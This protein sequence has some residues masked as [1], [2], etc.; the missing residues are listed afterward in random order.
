[1]PNDAPEQ[2]A[3][4]AQGAIPV[5]IAIIMDGNGRWA[6][7][8]GHNRVVGHYEG[9]ESV[10]DITEACAQLGVGYLTLYTFSTENW[11]RP[12]TEVDALM[13]LLIHSIQRERDT[14]MRN[15]IRL[16]VLGDLA[17]L[18]AACQ[19]A[20]L[21]TIHGT[22]SNTGLQLNL[23]LSYSGRWDLLQAVRRVAQAVQAGTLDPDAIDEATIDEH[24][25]THAMPDPDLLI[26]T[27][28]ELRISNFLLWQLAYTELFITDEFWPA[29]RRNHLYQAIAS[30]QQR[31]RRFGG[32]EPT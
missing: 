31:D 13:E 16:G 32:V 10:R 19:D 27:G 3:L 11:K 6:Q 20:L 7:H 5:H 23:A 15:N 22:A 30:F 12:R 9:V 8:Q 4:K 25:S 26:R 29:F 28:G 14:L 21:D 1:M 24:L 17:K 18:P 2:E